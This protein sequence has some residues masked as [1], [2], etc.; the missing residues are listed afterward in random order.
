MSS[1]GRSPN[2]NEISEDSVGKGW[3]INNIRVGFSGEKM[4]KINNTR[5]GFSG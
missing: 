5:I 4:E 1:R 2:G 3:K